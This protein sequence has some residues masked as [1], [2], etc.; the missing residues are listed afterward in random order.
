ML[1]NLASKY[2]LPLL[3]NMLCFDGNGAEIGVQR[4]VHAV[5]LRQ[6]WTKG[7]LHLIDSWQ[8]RA[9]YEDSAN[10]IQVQ[11]DENYAHVQLVFRGRNDVAVH[12]VDS[13]RAADMFPESYFDWI[14][15]DADHS[16]DAVKAELHH[17]EGKVR[18]GGIISGHDYYDGKFFGA[19]FGV[20]SA[21]DEWAKMRGYT[22]RL[23]SDDFCPSWFVLKN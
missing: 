11:Q 10:V 22:V 20:R 1:P 8:Y 13:L 16:Y 14:Y 12:K 5:H 18:E 7:K 19:T 3:F 23:A 2:D 15:L 17:W 6:F 4:G 9:D 21:V